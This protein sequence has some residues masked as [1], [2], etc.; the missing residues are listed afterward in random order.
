M[1]PIDKDGY[2]ELDAGGMVAFKLV[3]GAGDEKYLHLF[4]CHNGYYGHGFEFKVGDEVVKEGC[5]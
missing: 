4:N 1:I 3:N 5:L 2:N